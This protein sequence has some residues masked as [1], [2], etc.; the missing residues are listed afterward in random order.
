MAGMFVV[1][2]DR[3]VLSEYLSRHVGLHVYAIGDLDPFFWPH[4]RWFGW[5]E[6]DLQAVC[7]LYE[8]TTPPTLLALCPADTLQSMR[9]LLD[10]LGPTLPERFYGHFTPGLLDVFEQDWRAGM[11]RRHL[12]MVLP[13][14]VPLPVESAYPRECSLARIAPADLDGV[15]AFYRVNYPDNWFDA[16]MLETGQYVGIRRRC[17]WLAIAGVHVYSPEYHVAALGNIATARAHRGHGLGRQVTAAICR[18][19]RETVDTIGLNV[20]MDNVPARRCYDGLGF[21]TV[22]E[23][24]ECMVERRC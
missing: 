11:A 17:E 24:H 6:D 4:T 7:L 1:L 23:Y 10:A 12:K 8:A 19:L 9:C 13:R 2:H 22:A 3:S 15:Q 18:S 21:T 16:R 14:D 5:R 20:H